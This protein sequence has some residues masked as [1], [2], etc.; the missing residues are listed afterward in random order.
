MPPPTTQSPDRWRRRG[1]RPNAAALR[2]V[3]AVALVERKVE[4]IVGA[5]PARHIEGEKRKRKFT[6]DRYSVVP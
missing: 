2:V 6:N 5:G 1:W 4:W 3:S